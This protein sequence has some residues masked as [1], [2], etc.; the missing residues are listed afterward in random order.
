MEMVPQQAVRKG[1]RDGIDVFEMQIQKM[2]VIA[3][4]DENI[5]TVGTAIVDMIIG[6]VEKRGRAG[7]GY[8]I[9][10]P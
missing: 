3:L 6:I 1:F 8:P 4:L 5:F 10:S 9:I 7:H 2:L